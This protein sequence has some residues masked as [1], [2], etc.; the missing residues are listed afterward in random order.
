MTLSRIRPGFS[1]G[2]RWRWNPRHT[3]AIRR[4]GSPRRGCRRLSSELSF[5]ERKPAWKKKRS[6]E[7]GA[8]NRRVNQTGFGASFRPSSQRPDCLVSHS[9][10]ESVWAARVRSGTGCCDVQPEYAKQLGGDADRPTPPRILA[11]SIAGRFGPRPRSS[12]AGRTGCLRWVCGT[13]RFYD[14]SKLLPPGPPNSPQPP[15]FFPSIGGEAADWL[16]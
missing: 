3:H 13:P 6:G 12:S 8:G 16:P 11:G 15:E 7:A 1:R 4:P 2:R 10:S 9:A 14:W 5:L